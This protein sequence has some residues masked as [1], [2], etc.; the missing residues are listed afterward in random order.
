MPDR[1][2]H[3]PSFPGPP[4]G[5]LPPIETEVEYQAVKRVLAAHD[6]AIS[7]MSTPELRRGLTR[8]ANAMR[9]RVEEYEREHGG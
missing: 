6:E 8:W 9:R 2:E 1:R 4:G 5:E 7:L 3:Q